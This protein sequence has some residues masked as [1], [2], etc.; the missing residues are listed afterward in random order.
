MLHH[1]KTV[2][3]LICLDSSQ[4][5]LRTPTDGWHISNWWHRR[6]LVI[7]HMGTKEMEDSHGKE[8]AICIVFADT[9]FRFC[10]CTANLR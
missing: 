8:I 2:K 5:E 7:L 3:R 1:G 4:N 6:I 9:C 10:L